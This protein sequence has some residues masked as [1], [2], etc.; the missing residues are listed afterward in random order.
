MIRFPAAWRLDRLGISLKDL[1]GTVS[2]SEILDLGVK[3]S[4]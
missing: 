1:A 3:A 4:S 2:D